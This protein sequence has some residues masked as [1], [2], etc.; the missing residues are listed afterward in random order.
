[1]NIMSS[2]TVGHFEFLKPKFQKE[3]VPTPITAVI[4]NLFSRLDN[5]LLS[6]LPFCADAM[7][8]LLHFDGFEKLWDPQL[9]VDQ[10]ASQCEFRN[11]TIVVILSNVL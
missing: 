9:T 2:E 3:I 11:S 10:S 7:L 6:Q 5:S 4:D 8:S 1:M